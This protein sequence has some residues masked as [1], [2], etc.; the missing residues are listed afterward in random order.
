MN[1]NNFILLLITFSLAG[2]LSQSGTSDG[3]IPDLEVEC[4][5]VQVDGS[6]CN[7]SSEVLWIGITSD[8]GVDCG[9][10]LSNLSSHVRNSYFDAISEGIVLTQAGPVVYGNVSNWVTPLGASAGTLMEGTYKVCAFIEAS[11]GNNRLDMNE[12]LGSGLVTVGGSSPQ[13]VN[14]WISY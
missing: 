8:F 3:T 12:P 2:C 13:L 1:K 4:A 7:S 9:H 10:V 11:P 6:Y 5:Q 14:D